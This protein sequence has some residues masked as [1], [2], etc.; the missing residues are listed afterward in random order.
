MAT[1][2]VNSRI[3]SAAT[4]AIVLVASASEAGAQSASARANVS[5]RK[6][7]T[8]SWSKPRERERHCTRPTT[9]RIAS[10]PIPWAMYRATEASV[11]I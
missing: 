4:L 8:L 3:L 6:L 10:S 7:R 9:V 5:R 1:D 11:P 2:F